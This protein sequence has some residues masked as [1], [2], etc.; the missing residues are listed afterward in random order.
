MIT[1]SY[2]KAGTILFMSIVRPNMRGRAGTKILGRWQYGLVVS[3]VVLMSTPL[4]TAQ[5]AE[6]TGTPDVEQT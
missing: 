4:A 6:E 3:F 5:D 1:S 2:E